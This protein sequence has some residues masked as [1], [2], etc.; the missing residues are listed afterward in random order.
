MTPA[1][2]PNT[3]TLVGNNN[4]AFPANRFQAV[5]F[6]EKQ[7][8]SFFGLFPGAPAAMI[9]RTTFGEYEIT[10]VAQAKRF[11]TSLVEEGMLASIR[12]D[13]LLETAQNL[14]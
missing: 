12:R 1:D 9:V 2:R 11:L 10:N 13:D 7:S 5:D 8:G 6:R 4:F 3:P 14:L